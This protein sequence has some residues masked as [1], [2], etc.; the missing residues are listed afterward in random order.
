[1]TNGYANWFGTAL[2]AVALTGC[3]QPSDSKEDPCPNGGEELNVDSTSMCVYDTRNS[4]II[5]TGFECPADR[6]VR[7]DFGDLIVCAE[8]EPPEGTLDELAERYP[9]ADLGDDICTNV[10]CD[11]GE[12]C[13]EGECVAANNGNNNAACMPVTE[14][15]DSGSDEDCDELVDCD[16]PDCS[17]DAACLE[18]PTCEDVAEPN[19]TAATARGLGNALL[20]GRLCGAADEDWFELEGDDASEL[21]INVTATPTVAPNNGTETNIKAEL[22]TAA[23]EPV[24]PE[25]EGDAIALDSGGSTII[26]AT[27]VVRRGTPF[28]YYLKITGDDGL[29]YDVGVAANPLPRLSGIAEIGTGEG[30]S[31][32]RGDQ[33]ELWCWGRNDN[34]QLGDGSTNPSTTPVRV[35]TALAA[36]RLSVGPQHACAVM[37]DDSVRCW[38]DNAL[39]ELGVDPAGMPM[40]SSPVAAYYNGNVDQL[41]LGRDFTCVRDVANVRCWGSNVSDQLGSPGFVDSYSAYAQTV[42]NISDASDLAVGDAHACV[43]RPGNEVWCWGDNSWDQLSDPMIFDSSTPNA[44]QISGALDGPV[45]AESISAGGNWTAAHMG[46][47]AKGFG[48]IPNF[49]PMG[50]AGAV[51]DIPAGMFMAQVPPATRTIAG[52]GAWCRVETTGKVA[53]MGGGSWIEPLVRLGGIEGARYIGDNTIYAFLVAGLVNPRSLDIGATHMCAVEADGDA[54][55]WGQGTN[56]QLGHGATGHA[57]SPVFVRSP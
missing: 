18:P 3:S 33:G 2:V 40:A 44:L 32:A 48:Q 11:L 9:D 43:V 41:E 21:I 49:D 35:S 55:C 20:E 36:T 51:L 28:P 30:F 5:E 52:P 4:A 37:S 24:Y 31:C 26:S 23:G 12:T 54:I 42:A 14:V 38:G 10:V 47:S 19:G 50:G 56:G 27:V 16:D 13:V 39:G 1:M 29:P 34:G 8:E 17:N 22:V 53:C 57:A 25:G 46:D 6:S 7:R 15:C 45:Y